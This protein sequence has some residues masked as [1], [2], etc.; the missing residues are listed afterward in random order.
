[1]SRLNNLAK[2]NLWNAGTRIRSCELFLHHKDWTDVLRESRE[3]IDF[4]LKALLFGAGITPGKFQD[5][6]TLLLQH[7]ECFVGSPS[8]DW[9]RISRILEKPTGTDDP[10]MFAGG[11][12]MNF[13]DP[14][15][16]LAPPPTEEEARFLFSDAGYM[17]TL[18]EEFLRSLPGDPS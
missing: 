10:P 7:R 17:A 9:I 11:D 12:F 4:A 14:F 16:T 5:P 18:A 13:G 3:A 2:R 8:W 1:M 6:G 15:Q